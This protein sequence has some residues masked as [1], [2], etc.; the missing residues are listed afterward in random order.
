MNE[1]LQHIALKLQSKLF[2]LI[3]LNN[4]IILKN[5]YILFKLITTQYVASIL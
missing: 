3:L 4:K 1:V 2:L 5:S